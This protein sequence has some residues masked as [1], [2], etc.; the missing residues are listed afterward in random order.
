MGKV[1]QARKMLGAG[2]Y[3]TKLLT[4]VT[5][6]ATKIAKK[7]G[8]DRIVDACS[9]DDSMRDFAKEIYPKLTSDVKM[10][11]T[12]ENFVEHMITSKDSL[13]KKKKNQKKVSAAQRKRK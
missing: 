12:E 5:T 6:Q 9:S 10:K 13:M 1:S 4:Q 3:A 7:M 2:V 11:I 8:Y